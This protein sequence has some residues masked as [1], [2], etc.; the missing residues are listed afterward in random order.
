MGNVVHLFYLLHAACVMKQNNISLE[1]F[2]SIKMPFVDL[3]LVAIDNR[4]N[5]LSFYQSK[6]TENASKQVK[7]RHN[8]LHYSYLL[9][10][11]GN[12]SYI[13]DTAC[14]AFQRPGRRW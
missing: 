5:F 9:L 3:K 1:Q 10:R 12:N 8:I 2:V 4:S 7:Q 11:Q 14:F 6:I 13:I